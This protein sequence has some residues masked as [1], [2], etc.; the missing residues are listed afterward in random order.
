MKK[1]FLIYL[2]LFNAGC[3]YSGVGSKVYWCGDHACINSKEKEEYFKKTMIVEIK[4]TSD[5]NKNDKSKIQGV[6]DQSRIYEIKD[7]EAEKK[8]AKQAKIDKKR[9]IKNEKEL[10]KQAELEEKRRIKKEKELAKQAKLDKKRRIQ[11][12]KE[13]SKKI[14][15][16]EKR[17]IKNKVLKKN[18][19]TI[20][21]ISNNKVTD[22]FTNAF[23]NIIKRNSFKEYP[24]IN[25]IE[26]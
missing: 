19:D 12:E 21:K 10:A 15:I 7:S 16:D 26:Y 4:N 18:D 22:K 1:Y 23:E 9:R 24:D 3:S 14:K 11:N 25:K 8:I 17:L 20:L 5:I 2:L 13:L 6:L